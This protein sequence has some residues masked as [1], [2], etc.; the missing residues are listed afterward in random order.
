MTRLDSCWDVALRCEP[1]LRKVM[2]RRYGPDL[3]DELWTDVVIERASRVHELYDT[4]RDVNSR[5]VDIY[6]VG[7]MLWYAH[8][9]VAKIKKRRDREEYRESLP[10]VPVGDT[11]NS[12]LEYLSTRLSDFECWLLE[13]VAVHG[14]EFSQIAEVCDTTSQTV[15]RWYKETLEKAREALT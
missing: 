2:T 11:S 6:F 10:D 5:G 15:G 8:K 7:T 3:C 12:V 4:R 14:F 1:Y 9:H 13:H